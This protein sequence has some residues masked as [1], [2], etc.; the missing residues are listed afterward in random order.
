M[1]TMTKST[2]ALFLSAVTIAAVSLSSVAAW[3]APPS[4]TPNAAGEEQAVRH[5]EDQITEALAHNDADALSKL[6]APEYMFINPAGI[7]IAGPQR[8]AM[9]RSGELKVDTYT[10]D[11]E[12]IHVYGTTAVV[13]YRSTVGAQRNGQ[14]ISSRR[15]VMTVLVKRDGRW[16]VVAQQSTAIAQK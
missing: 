9:L 3:S 1:K 13:M 8:L 10:R 15:R 11:D 6:W 5:V 4:A 16:Q 12:S 14:D 7:V 2:R